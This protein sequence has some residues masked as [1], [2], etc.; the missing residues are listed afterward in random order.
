MPEPGAVT[1]TVLQ[2]DPDLAVLQAGNPGPMTL[3]GTN[4]FVIGRQ[5]VAIVDPGPDDVAQLDAIEALVGDRDVTHL[6][7]THA[8]AD[9]A[10][11]ATRA[12]ERFGVP[13]TAS[14]ATLERQGLRGIAV[15]DGD[16]LEVERGCSL[17]A[18]HAPGHSSDHV[19][20]L[21]TPDRWLCSGDLVLGR[22][23]SAILYPDGRVADCLA[24]LARLIALRPG[25][26]LPGHGPTVEPAV[27]HLEAYR[28]HRLER[29]REVRDAIRAGHATVPDI[30]DAVYGRL[31]DG[32]AWAADASIAAHLAYQAARGERVPSFEGFGAAEDEAP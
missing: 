1:P 4:T 23:S 18:I 9:H 10:G 8:H 14:A 5:A 22:G 27:P 7:L 11:L 19:C 6:L 29:D 26:L 17:V 24:S 25:R 16:R 12:A 21:R 32:L 20:Y 31:P 28:R 13:P 30:R 3:D 15:D 2:R